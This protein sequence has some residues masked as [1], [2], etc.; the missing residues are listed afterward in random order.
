MT[1]IIFTYNDKVVASKRQFCLNNNL[2]Y[3]ALQKKALRAKELPITILVNDL[4]L[5]ITTQYK[6]PAFVNPYKG[7]AQAAATAKS[8]GVSLERAW[9]IAEYK[10]R[11]FTYVTKLDNIVKDL[12]N[13]AK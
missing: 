9:Q 7:L 5:V 13:A 2:K 8:W 10:T 11:I 3:S 4:P 1:S 6:E 12:Q